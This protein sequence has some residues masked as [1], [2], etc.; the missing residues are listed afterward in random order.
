[1]K[2]NSVMEIGV[3]A[4]L[5][6]GTNPFPEIAKLGLTTVQLQN[7]DMANL[8]PETA[9]KTKRDMAES[10]I[11]PAAFWGGYTGKIVWNSCGGPETCGLVP[12]DQRARRVEEL[13]RG[14]DFA[15]MIGAPA[16]VTHC[17]FIPENPMDPLYRETVEAVREVAL[18]CRG[19]GIDFWFEAGQET[20]LTLLRTI[21][22][23]GLDNLGVNLDTA[24]LILYGKGNPVDAMEVVGKY[25]RNLHIKDGL[26]P[27]DGR[28]LG[29]E[30][31][32]GEGRADFDR[33]ISKLYELDFDG[34]L[35]IEREITGPQQIADIVMAAAELR[36][37][38][39]K[40][41]PRRDGQDK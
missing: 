33:I 3:M 34:E 36:K 9:E 12:R 22:D 38:L 5:R 18:H 10:G 6:K 31:P 39:E 15:K 14:A 1:M 32:F 8:D 23:V 28:S 21:E 17:G 40:H 37:L 4:R 41:R 16:L 2:G 11:R 26:F 13:K 24:N 29:K 20:P 27:T 7:W 19:L 30:V 25:V 35:I